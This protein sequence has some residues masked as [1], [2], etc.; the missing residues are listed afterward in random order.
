[1]HL[2]LFVFPAAVVS[3][4]GSWTCL[5]SRLVPSCLLFLI[6]CSKEIRIEEMEEEE[7]ENSDF[8]PH[9]VQ[10][11]TKAGKSLGMGP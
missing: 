5:G 2:Q 11:M 6:A 9:A 10:C 1:M 3:Y 4:P 7:E 8:S